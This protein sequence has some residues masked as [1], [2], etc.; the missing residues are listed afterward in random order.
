MPCARRNGACADDQFSERVDEREPLSLGAW[1]WASRCPTCGTMM[2]EP[3]ESM[4]AN[5]S[6]PS[7][8]T[9]MMPEF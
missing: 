7:H 4:I 6:V 1:H 2:Y 5:T 9:N 8:R 3:V